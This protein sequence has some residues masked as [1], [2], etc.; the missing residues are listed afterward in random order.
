MRTKGFGSTWHLS[1]S[2][3]K[4][5][6][7]RMTRIRILVI[8]DLILDEFI[9][10]TVERISPEAPVPVVWAERE[11]AMPGGAANVASNVRALGGQA[12]LLGIV[13]PDAGGRRLRQELQ[14][15]GLSTD[16][17]FVDRHRPTTLKTR[18]V[19]QHQQVVRIDRER[20]DR[21]A[22]PALEQVL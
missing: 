11:S 8:G 6:L 20:V 3:L 22:G 1:R 12:E 4:R 10:G 16:G 5:I 15:R 19:A 21:V 13:G 7:D 2:R 17:I 14:G 9:W 18:V